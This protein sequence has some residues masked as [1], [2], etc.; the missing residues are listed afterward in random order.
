MGQAKRD[1]TGGE[2]EG[3]VEPERYGGRTSGRLRREKWEGMRECV[4]G[5]S[6]TVRR[7]LVGG[8]NGE[9]RAK[10]YRT[11]VLTTMITE[12][13]GKRNFGDFYLHI[14]C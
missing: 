5:E 2:G 1:V 4:C 10:V 8:R 6:R 3:R 12:I 11:S 13:N 9:R 7:R 14:A